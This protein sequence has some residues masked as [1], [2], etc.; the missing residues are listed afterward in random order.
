MS[1]RDGK[2]RKIQSQKTPDSLDLHLHTIVYQ[3]IPPLRLKLVDFLQSHGIAG[4]Y[5]DVLC[6]TMTELLTNLVKH[7]EKKASDIRLSARI[8]QGAIELEIADDG[9]PFATFDAKCKEALSR[10]TP[11]QTMEETGY[12]LGC[13][14]RSHTQVFYREK[15]KGRDGFN[16]FTIRDG[17]E[18]ALSFLPAEPPPKQEKKPV[19]FLI[20]DDPTS[21]TV[22]EAMLSS[23]Y[24][25]VT[26]RGAEQALSAFPQKRPALVISDLR[27]PG[28]DGASLRRA[29]SEMEGG[30]TTPFVFLSGVKEGENNSYISRLGVDDFLG[31]PIRQEKLLSVVSRLLTR[32]QQVRDA[33]QGK[34]H[35]DLTDIL[36]PALPAHYAGWNITTLNRMAEAGGGD[37]TFYQETPD[38]LLAVLADVMG[39]GAQAKFFAYAYAGYLRSLF[40]MSSSTP[41]AARFLQSVS[42][43]VHGDDFLE[44]TLVT[45]Q[46]FQFFP[47]G[48]I[49]AASAGHPAPLLI[50]KEKSV[51]IDIAGPLPGM[52]DSGRYN[53]A[54]LQ[55]SAGDKIL[56]ATDGFFG[57]FDPKGA[58]PAALLELASRI[59]DKTGE[60]IAQRLWRAFEGK[61][62]RPA[63]QKD[64]ATLIIAEYGGLT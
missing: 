38:C 60:D 21:L 6:L 13:I 46:S 57:A 5:A 7:P 34:F 14:L 41:D 28:M 39:H 29:L 2:E 40:R 22:E 52:T 8:R 51:E 35:Q 58:G 44:N 47:G 48:K 43:A 19:I 55:M 37:F 56:F 31:K 54:S 63:H 64:D 16:R 32:T 26:F 3:D 61:S 42:A 49:I 9:S 20:D 25:V 30:D 45:C 11:V 36:K 15:T 1:A 33:L 23:C 12:G 53:P 17:L 27:M 59:A 4:A 18:K 10:G 24:D 50:R 62:R